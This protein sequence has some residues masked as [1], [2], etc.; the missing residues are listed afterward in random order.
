MPD[1]LTPGGLWV[2]P[3]TVAAS[4][5]LWAGAA[6]PT[7]AASATG[8]L[9]HTGGQIVTVNQTAQPRELTWNTFNVGANTTLRFNQGGPTGR[10]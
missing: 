2:D 6:L 1:G 8:A 3:A 5:A 10:C 4:P 7:A 9:G